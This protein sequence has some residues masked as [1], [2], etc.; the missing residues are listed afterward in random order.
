MIQ[1]ANNLP[2]ERTEFLINDRLLFM[3]FLGLG[4]SD[5]VPDARTYLPERIRKAQKV[6]VQFARLRPS[7][8]QSGKIEYFKIRAPPQ[9]G[10][11]RVLDGRLS[12][13]FHPAESFLDPF[14]CAVGAANPPLTLV[15][16]AEPR[17]LRT[18][19]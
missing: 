2:D 15:A 6:R 11:L 5:Q 9:S 12:S 19:C 18:G 10:H 7:R 4:L 17:G 16:E 3:R 13:L 8:P 1:T 14:G